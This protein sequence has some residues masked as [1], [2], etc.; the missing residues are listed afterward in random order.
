VRKFNR[1]AG[2]GQEL[3]C[4]CGSKGSWVTAS[5]LRHSDLV[6]T[7]PET[8][9]TQKQSGRNALATHSSRKTEK[10]LNEKR[11][12]FREHKS[13]HTP[14]QAATCAHTRTEEKET[15]VL[16][17]KRNQWATKTGR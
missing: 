1:V 17:S 14:K 10:A 12:S 15:K 4:A 3:L 5:I 8:S 9:Y 7:E 6:P 2:S 16:C 11:K 13:A